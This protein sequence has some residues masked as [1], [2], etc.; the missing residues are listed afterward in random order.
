MLYWYLFFYVKKEYI[1]EVEMLFKCKVLEIDGD[2]VGVSEYCC[3]V[4]C[5]DKEKGS[6]MVY[7]VKYVLKNIGGFGIDVEGVDIVLDE[8]L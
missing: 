7:I 4:E 3:K 2:E 8:V 5:C 1:D 6:V